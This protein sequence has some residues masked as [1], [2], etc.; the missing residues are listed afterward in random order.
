MRYGT[1]KSIYNEESVPAVRQETRSTNKVNGS[2]SNRS[3]NS[4]T[5]LNR[6]G[7][8]KISLI[9]LMIISGF[10][11]VNQVFASSEKSP[12]QERKVVVESGDSLWGIAQEYKPSNMRTVVYMQAIREHNH[13]NVSGLQAGQVISVPIYE[14]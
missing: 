4:I 1:Y 3:V 6:I 10:T 7:M 11:L 13:L 9:L 2:G 8:F 12:Q 14:E 5:V